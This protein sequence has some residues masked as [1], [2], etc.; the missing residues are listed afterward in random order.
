MN[1]NSSTLTVIARVS[2]LSLLALLACECQ[3][4]SS[5]APS[6]K[7]TGNSGIASATSSAQK[8]LFVLDH[9]LSIG[10]WDNPID[11][12]YFRDEEQRKT[13]EIAFSKRGN[14]LSPHVQ[15]IRGSE[16]TQPESHSHSLVGFEVEAD[17]TSENVFNCTRWT[18]SKENWKSYRTSKYQIALK[19]TTYKIT[20]LGKSGGMADTLRSSSPR[21]NGN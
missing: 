9:Y 19:G 2:C 5:L 21:G 20:S 6:G 16:L 13:L 8:E 1:A 7:Q 3:R 11:V 4:T 17:A 10:H 18:G 14:L 15:Y 12:I